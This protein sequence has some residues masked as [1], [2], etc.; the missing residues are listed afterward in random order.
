ML[1]SFHFCSMTV[2]LH[3]VYCWCCSGQLLCLYGWFIVVTSRNQPKWK[4]RPTKRC[5]TTGCTSKRKAIFR[6]AA[7]RVIP[8]SIYL[9]TNCTT[10]LAIVIALLQIL[11]KL[12]WFIDFVTTQVCF[13]WSCSVNNYF[14]GLQVLYFFDQFYQH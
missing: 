11:L 5:L 14:A 13:L 8:S 6:G 1:F 2:S 4:N 12:L 7:R 9:Y 3:F 10:S